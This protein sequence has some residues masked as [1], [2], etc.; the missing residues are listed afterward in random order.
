MENRHK[1][2][3]SIGGTLPEDAPTYVKRKADDELY[4]GLKAGEF[5]YVLNS[6]QT[7]K[8]SLRVQT[9][10][11]L[12]QDRI[13]CAVIDLSIGGTQYATPEQW[14]VDMIDTLVESFDLDIDL[15]TWWYEY[16][17]F[18]PA[19]RLNK[20]IEGVLLT[21]VAE[22]I[23]IFIDEIDSVL[24]LNF[25]TDDFFAFIRGCYNHLRSENPEYNRLTFCLLGV[26]TPSDLIQDK[27][28]TPFNIGRAI[29][30]TGFTLDEAKSS[31]IQG[32]VDKVDNPEQVLKNVLAWTE[33]Q[34]FLTQKLCKLVVEK[35]NSR[36]PNI[37]QL[38]QKY[39]IDNWESQD[40]P[41]H[42][43]T[44]R[45]RIL[46]NEQR[47]S[48]LLGLYQQILQQGEIA[49]DDSSEQMELRLSGLVVKQNGK[50]RVYNCI[51]EAVFDQSWVKQQLANLRPYSEAFTA[52]SK[53]NRQ[54]ESRLLRGN[55]LQDALTWA[56]N[57][58]LSAEDYTFL[59]TSQELDRQYIQ[60]ELN[61]E[62]KA[63]QILEKARKEAKEGTRLERQGVRAL[64]QFSNWSREIEELL[65]AMEAGQSLQKMVQD[66]RSL[67]D[68]P[69]TSPL[70]ALQVILDNIRERNQFKVN[71]GRLN[72]VSL[73]P[74]GEYIITVSEDG[75]ANLWNL[76]GYQIAEFI[77]HEG[78][79]KA[80]S[81]S[82]KGEYIATAS[83]DGTARLWNLSGHQITKFAGHENEINSVSFSPTGQYVTTNSKDDIARLWDLYGHQ[84]AEF[85]KSSFRFTPQGKYIVT[86]SYDR[87]RWW[88][89]S[90]N[91]IAEFIGNDVRNRIIRLWD[92][93]GHQ[94]AEFAG[95]DFVGFSPNGNYVATVSRASIK[96]DYKVMLWDLSGQRL[97]EFIGHEEEIFKVSFSP[98]GKYIAT[99]SD[100]G[101]ARVWNLSGKQLAEL[102]HES[103]VF[104]VVFSPDGQY[105]ATWELEG[106][107]RLW[108]LSGNQIAEAETV[109]DWF[110]CYVD[111][112]N[113]SADGHY[114][115]TT[116]KYNFSSN[117]IFQL[118]N[119]SG[120]QIVEFTGEY[121]SP[122]LMRKYIAIP[123]EDGTIKLWDLS[124]KKKIEFRG[125]QNNLR[126][127]SFIAKG[128]FIATT[129]DGCTAQLWDL[130]GN[131]IAKFKGR[132]VSFSPK[133]EFIATTSDGCTA[134]LW[135][136]SGNQIVEFIGHQDKVTSVTFSP[137]GKYIATASFDRTARLW[138][139]YGNQIVEFIG[140]HGWVGIG[141]FSPN[142]K[143]FATV[144]SDC[145]AR[146][147]DLAG[148]QLAL[149]TGHQ[150][151][152]NSVS[153]SPNG[154]YIA[155][156]SDDGTARLWDLSGNQI[157]EFRGHKDQV[158]SISFSP[159]GHYIATTSFD[160]TAVLWDLSGNQITQF[161]GH[162]GGVLKVCF[163]PNSECI[164]TA[165]QD[166]TARIWDLSGNQIAEFR[167]HQGWIGDVSFSPDGKYLATASDDGTARLWRV[168]TLDELLA[169]G[170]D[171][172]KYYLASH[173][174]A[175]EKLKVCQNY[176][177]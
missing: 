89:L 165:S 80:V 147:W 154:K 132:D 59:T 42:L 30:L 126:S 151:W 138:D 33:G 118:L 172:L 124:G 97:A 65:L 103:A 67:E 51:Y 104:F 73:S 48:R 53:S 8:S 137:N 161:W 146:L 71:P 158:M 4:E 145:T 134:Q 85:T 139:L 125:H 1:Y 109:L 23:V 155:T 40:E 15:S 149:F 177:C 81:F 31:L 50:L 70:L 7:G 39:V 78:G 111:S 166:G 128:E 44:I 162:Q 150:G 175:G 112:F 41:E 168:E 54:D 88:D 57:K 102:K 72:A 6:R 108:D 68:Y 123:Q 5:C 38:V 173:P 13:A 167:G 163:S 62:R 169:R 56:K 74:D 14:Y 36:K 115:A 95:L 96:R 75:R 34:P 55:A 113:F 114:I 2:E 140:H 170:C 110:D 46:S 32:L 153:F 131:Q 127:V 93:S 107:T 28:R 58:S 83:E 20:F 171:W 79:I 66:G 174:E 142:G 12:R 9:M 156:T 43:R 148:N 29:D 16:N 141:C 47:T 106:I 91:Q 26:T 17:L 27:K 152:V 77:G 64:Q 3:Y 69:A 164:A 19:K 11:R 129:S 87:I 133:G 101:T 24:S 144:S 105:L 52:W 60:R 117:Y 63:K 49:A 94:I 136:L 90:G 130:S 143:Y 119:L 122:I 135:D 160:H 98:D 21:Q 121:P 10:R 92:L 35:T 159:N 18:S 61:T 86:D 116:Y 22:S 37:K 99:A 157:I 76:S 45:D 25:P 82:P 84:I 176:S 120:I 100:D